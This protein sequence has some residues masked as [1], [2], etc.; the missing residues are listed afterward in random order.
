MKRFNIDNYKGSYVMHC[1]TET[2]ARE[3]CEYLHSIGR[4]WD[5]GRSYSK[6]NYYELYKN[7]IAYNFNDGTVCDVDYYRE[8]DYTILEFSDFDWSR[9]FTKADLK[10]GDVVLHRDG[11]TS[12]V[13]HE[14]NLMRGFSNIKGDFYCFDDFNDDLTG[15]DDAT[16]SDIIEVRRPKRAGECQPCA[17]EEN[18]GT[19]VYKRKEPEEMTLEQV[20]KLLGKEI[21]IIP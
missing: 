2:E 17:F 14:L 5:S 13:I 15:T 6:H 16:Y 10:T 20:C 1:K 8:C 4:R 11:F 3:F 21:K 12:V 9:E 7:K 19:L 18:L